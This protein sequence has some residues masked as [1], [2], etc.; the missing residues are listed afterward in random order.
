[1]GSGRVSPAA[2]VTDNLQSV[3]MAE[4]LRFQLEMKRLEIEAANEA[5]RLE[6]EERREA[7]RLE[8]EAEARRLEVEERN[9]AR[10]LDLEVRRLEVEKHRE[11][12][13][14]RSR[15]GANATHK[16]GGGE[17]NSV[18]RQMVRSLQLIP[19]FD[20]Q[21]VAEW[22]RRFE[23]KAAEFGWPGEMGWPCGQ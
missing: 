21:K 2:S 15:F 9:E 16:G 11:F 6:A 7:R 4:E 13:W 1:M 18:E 10:R 8:A 22:F 14:E 12:E 19:D 5:R 20:E 23:K 17:E 3:G